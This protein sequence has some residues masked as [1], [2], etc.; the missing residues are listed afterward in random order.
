MSKSLVTG[1]TGFI[2]LYVVKLLLERGHHVNTTVRNLENTTKCK[3]LLDLQAKYSTK[4]KLFE[5]D[6]MEHGS[7]RQAME[8]CE[9]VYHIASPF[10][11]PQQI[12][13]GLKECV[14]PALQGTKNVLQS[15]NDVESVKR[16]VL[17]SSVAA[18]YGDNA[19]VLKVKDQTLSESCWNETSSVSYA[20]YAYS[21]TVAEREAWE[22]HS[23][24]NRWSLVVINPGMV[25]GPSMTSES[26]SGSLF[27]LEAMYRGENRMGCADLSWPLVDVRDVAEAHVKVGA[28]TATKGRYIISG[29]HT[30]SL[31]EMANL[32]RP[33]HQNPKVLPCWNLPK[34]MVYAAGPFIGIS[35]K[36]SDAN[37]GIGFKVDNSKSIKEL[38]MAYRSAEEAVQE[39]YKSWLKNAKGA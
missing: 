10:L 19:D 9:V 8:G 21:K 7:F 17:T 25:L 28:N 4:L 14:E 1:G 23:L 39:H 22:I 3:P 13:D 29:D 12:K 5:A 24:Q 2:G 11:V 6:L 35:K 38:G 36:W 18:T 26:V 31:L 37:M 33:I 20:P 32:V 16:V 34:L 30:I 27:M 15:A